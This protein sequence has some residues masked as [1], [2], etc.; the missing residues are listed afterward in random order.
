MA[1]HFVV[2]KISQCLPPSANSKHYT[3]LPRPHQTHIL[4]S[5]DSLSFPEN[6][7]DRRSPCEA[8]DLPP[9][10]VQAKLLTSHS[11]FP[12]AQQVLAVGEGPQG[13]WLPTSLWPSHKVSDHRLMRSASRH[14]RR[15]GEEAEEHQQQCGQDR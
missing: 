8:T 14:F 4:H 6:T 12:E 13:G 3:L 15:F 5:G 10:Q 7:M 1:G 2:P 11:I 9:D